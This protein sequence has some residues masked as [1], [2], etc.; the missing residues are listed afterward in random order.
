VDNEVTPAAILQAFAIGFVLSLAFVPLCRVLARRTGIV[1][2]PRGDRWHRTS[3]PLLGGLAIA[4]SLLI[5]SIVTGVAR[6]LVVPLVA[7]LVLSIVGLIDDKKS[8]NAS[9]KLIAQIA[10]AAGVVFFGYRLQWIDSR[11]LDSLVTIIWL[12]GLSNA[13]N[14]LDNMDGLCASIS[15]VAAVMLISGLLTGVTAHL[16]GPQITYLAVLAGAA[17]GFLVY[18]FPP[19]SVFMGDTGSMLLGFTLASLTLS[20][21]GVRASRSDVLS[22]IA[23]PVFVLLIPIFDTSLVTL[24]RIFSGRSP[25]RGG[26]DHSSHRL[27]ALGL[28]ERAALLVLSLLAAV[29]GAIGILIRSV[30]GGLSLLAGAVFL[31]A[32]CVFAAYLSRI[33]VYEDATEPARFGN[34]TPLV[35][36]FMYKR[37]VAEVLLDFCL[38]SIAY[39]SAYRLRFEGGEYLLNVENFYASLPVVLAAQLIAF[40]I[41]GVY[42]GLWH[43]FGLL[44]SVTIVKGVVVGTATAQLVILYLYHYFSYSRTVFLIYAIL[45]GGLVILSRASFRLMAEF[46]QR[47]RAGSHRAVIYG[48]GENAGLAV[49]ELQQHHNHSVK[50]LGFIDDDPKTTRLRVAGY[51]VLGGYA[52]LEVLAK[53]GSIDTVILSR[54]IH[55]ASRLATIHDLCAHHGIQL[56]RLNIGVEELVPV[57]PPAADL[58]RKSGR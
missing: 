49:R 27:V 2:H 37:R 41:V 53:T 36:N 35:A 5:G 58:S 39:Y 43:Y 45:V 40:F 28:S 18:N 22:I 9:T 31:L 24:N 54:H 15:L 10:V 23:G 20:A 29:G 6:E 52:A 4:A 34:I 25:A 48:A 12:V 55:E 44:D 1:A 51:S 16:A 13:L 56:L 26:R 30:S 42:R 57:D 11:M 50:I 19:A 21:E 8:L 47:R 17:A 32:M 46:I 38:I 14:L 33:R 7:A 3:V